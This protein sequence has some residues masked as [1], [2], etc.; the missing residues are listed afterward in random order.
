MGSRCAR[1]RRPLSLHMNETPARISLH[2]PAPCQANTPPSCAA[3][4]AS[5]A[6][7]RGACSSGSSE[8]APSLTLSRPRAAPRT[9]MGTLGTHMG[10]L[11]HHAHR[12][13]LRPHVAL[14]VRQT[15]GWL[16]SLS[17]A[18]RPSKGAETSLRRNATGRRRRHHRR[19]RRRHLP[20]PLRVCRRPLRGKPRARR[21]IYRSRTADARRIRRASGG[22]RTR[23]GPA[24]T[25]APL[26]GSIA[27]ATERISTLL[28]AVTTRALSVQGRGRVSSTY[29]N[30]HRAALTAVRTSSTLP[31]PVLV[32]A[33]AA[34]PRTQP[35]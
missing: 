8:M 9:H 29:G 3:G 13:R 11:D 7:W 6:L 10:T 1:A 30:T 2:A 14:A 18:R 19:Q 26:V 17:L 4:Y 12:R 33:R 27:G 28:A 5:C 16:N 31:E 35:P 32:I 15:R 20:L 21:P 25:G 22:S 23:V 24:P 34:P